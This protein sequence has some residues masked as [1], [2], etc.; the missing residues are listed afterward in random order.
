M[1]DSPRVSEAPSGTGDTLDKG[2]QGVCALGFGSQNGQ[3][4]KTEHTRQ[5][6]DSQKQWDTGDITCHASCK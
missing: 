6:L 5:V 2:G 3:L 4:R 1:H